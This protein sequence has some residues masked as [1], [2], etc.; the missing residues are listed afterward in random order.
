[1]FSGR[2]RRHRSS[3]RSL[4]SGGRTPSRNQSFK[5]PS[6]SVGAP[7]PFWTGLSC[8]AIMTLLGGDVIEPGWQFNLIVASG[9]LALCASI[10]D[11]GL[12]HLRALPLLPRLAL[13][14]V[15]LLPIVQIIPLP[16]SI[17]SGFPGRMVEREV[18]GI[19]GVSGDWLPISIEPLNTMMAVLLL[20]PLAA[21]FLFALRATD[22]ESFIIAAAL[23]G[24]A[25]LAGVI[26]IVQ[27]ASS[28]QAF[29]FYGKAFR[30]PMLGLVTNRNHMALHMATGIIIGGCIVRICM[31]R[32]LVATAVAAAWSL[33]LLS[34][35]LGTASRAGFALGCLA[36]LLTMV[37]F[38][39]LGS[40]SNF[41]IVAFLGAVIGLGM[42]AILLS[43]AFGK[44]IA[45]LSVAGGDVRWSIWNQ[46]MRIARDY[47]PFGAGLGAF[48]NVYKKYEQVDGVS[49]IYMN[50]AHQEYIQVVLEAGCLGAVALVLM[51]SAWAWAMIKARGS[52]PQA[53]RQTRL[54]AIVGGQVVLLFGLH[55]V[56]DYP[57]RTSTLSAIFAVSLAWLMRTSLAGRIGAD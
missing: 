16:P 14:F 45:R 6:L 30:G 52:D 20:A 7:L 51:V 49:T 32:T 37:Q 13:G 28:G 57:L 24:F 2:R 8:L 11:G 55:S 50:Q 56:V 36:A 15:V 10:A 4:A 43:G 21:L 44:L 46:S 5:M 53:D 27:F 25:L 33:L 38:I 31:G 1:V 9:L 18:Y 47:F 35:I 17:W 22:A 26:G 48:E 29:D 41:R 34:L 3:R 40:S 23:C 19:I 12:E 39:R 42:S 54:M